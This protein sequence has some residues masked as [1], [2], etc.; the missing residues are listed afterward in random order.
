M[1]F[2][3]T[4][5][6]RAVRYA[7]WI[8]A[9]IVFCAV[10]FGFLLSATWTEKPI[11][12]LAAWQFAPLALRAAQVLSQGVS[13]GAILA[14]GGM[15]VAALVSFLVLVIASAL[16][17]RWYCAF[18]CPL[19]FVQDL[20]ALFRKKRRG[21]V[22]SN[23]VLRA[24]ALACFVALG[25]GGA[26][27]L[28]SW[29]EPWSLTGRFFAYDAQPLARLLLRVDSPLLPWGFIA[30]PG[31]AVALVVGSAA[32]RGRWFCNNLCPV[33]SAFGIL[34]IIA[35]FRLRLD[36]EGCS[37]CGRCSTVCLA[38]CLDGKSR[39]LDS[40]RCVY[41]LECINVCPSKAVRY[42]RLIH[43]KEIGQDNR[44]TRID[45]KEKRQDNR[46]TRIDRKEKGQDN[47]I[48]RIDKTVTRSD[49]LG[50]MWNSLRVGCGAILGAFLGAGPATL[51]RNAMDAGGFGPAA[52]ERGN[53]NAAIAKASGPVSPPGSLST[54]RFV[55]TCITCGLCVA[56]CPS[57]ILRPSTGQ[58]G[59]S[60]LFAPRLDYD[61][62]YCQFSCTTCLDLCPSGAL[63]KLSP[64]EKQ[65]TKIGDATLVRDLCIVIKNGTKCG[66]LPHRGGANGAGEV[67]AARTGVHKLD[68]HRLRS[69]PPCLPCQA[70]KGHNCIRVA[71]P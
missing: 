43:R 31:I 66:A 22:K 28:A 53:A 32:L 39:H 29:I 44:I 49:F 54:S 64:E 8:A 20:M 6:G 14:A 52:A 24:F 13:Q 38:D 23:A 57:K 70:A 19:G 71:D 11:R 55:G 59:L 34:N 1:I 68:M 48:S 12:V 4:K 62:S 2:K 67:K 21:Y 36:A 58:L 45:R 50:A 16:F 41:C 56:R 46:I 7:R 10:V 65:R 51:A 35:P 25:L 63:V 60:G 17:G 40:S 30:A 47:R 26:L 3:G 33:G 69:L 61:V 27:G 18:L 9:G 37:A 15:G 42:G 5:R